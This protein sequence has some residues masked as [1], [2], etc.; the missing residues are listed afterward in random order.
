MKGTPSARWLACQERSDD[1]KEKGNPRSGHD[2]E[3][4][5][6]HPSGILVQV[7]WGFSDV[8]AKGTIPCLNQ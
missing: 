7:V 2:K 8:I 3:R 4:R 5:D 6:L 1:D